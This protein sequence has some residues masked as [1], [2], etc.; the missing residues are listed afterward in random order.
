MFVCSDINFVLPRD[1]GGDLDSWS[2]IIFD[3]GDVSPGCL[4]WGV[5]HILVA[6]VF[7]VLLDRRE[8]YD[9]KLVRLLEFSFGLITEYDIE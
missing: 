4:I 5:I 3:L 7:I 1:L 6:I 2:V 9:K 8:F